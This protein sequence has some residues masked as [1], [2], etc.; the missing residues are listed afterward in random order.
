MV[1]TSLDRDRKDRNVAPAAAV[2]SRGRRR[3]LDAFA[4]FARLEGLSRER[5]RGGSDWRPSEGGYMP[6]LH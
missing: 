2:K 3:K 5:D 4:S 1:S 6:L